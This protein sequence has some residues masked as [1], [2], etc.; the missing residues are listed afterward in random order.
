MLCGHEPDCS[1][2]YAF[3]MGARMPTPMQKAMVVGFSLHERDGN[4]A[5]LRFVL[6]PKSLAW[7]NDAR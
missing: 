5:K 4:E 2:L 3:L 6:D 1:Q 7:E